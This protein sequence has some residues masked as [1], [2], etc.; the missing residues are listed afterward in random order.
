MI[1]QFY[2][3]LWFYPG[4][5]FSSVY[6]LM[7]PWAVSK[8]YCLLLDSPFRASSDLCFLRVQCWKEPQVFYLYISKG[9]MTST[10]PGSV[11]T[12]FLFEIFHGSKACCSVQFS[13][14]VGSDSLW[15][16]GLQNSRPP[17]P[18]PTP[19]VYLNSR[20]LSRWCH[21]TNSSSVDPFSSC[22]Q[23]FPASGS[24][25]MSQLFTSGA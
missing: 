7:D 14:S 19:R 15:P 23:S 10:Q 16:H 3:H 18:S 9:E 17:C 21:P 5:V 12:W 8:S 4:T 11:I 22:L 24:F 6:V 20:P 2:V 1:S 13:C 25:Q